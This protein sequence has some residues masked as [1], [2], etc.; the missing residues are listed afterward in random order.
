MATCRAKF[1]FQ[2]QQAGDLALRKGDV[3]TN[4][5]KQGQWWSGHANGQQ[6]Q[7]PSNYVE[8]IAGTYSFSAFLRL[9]LFKRGIRHSR[10]VKILN[11]IV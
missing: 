3:I 8:E 7:F 5:V 6:G 9:L 2:A 4:V 1:D 11:A 10:R